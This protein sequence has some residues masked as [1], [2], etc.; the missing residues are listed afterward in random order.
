MKIIWSRVAIER[1]EEIAD[2]IAEE[3]PT[4]SQKWKAL[5]YQKVQRLRKFPKSGRKVPEA[6]RDEIREVLY[7]N[8]RIIYGIEQEL[9]SILTVRHGK[10]LLDVNE[11]TVE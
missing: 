1:I 3:N 5:I 8:Y 9:I 7:K 6:N 11:I 10:E 2:F 4:A